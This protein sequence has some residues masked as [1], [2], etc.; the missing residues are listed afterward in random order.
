MQARP[1]A[2]S[3]L[4]AA[5]QSPTLAPVREAPRR[6]P[7]LVSGQQ[8]AQGH[9]AASSSG[10]HQRESNLAAFQ[11]A[12][13]TAELWSKHRGAL[14]QYS[15]NDQDLIRTCLSLELPSI[16]PRRTRTHPGRRSLTSPKELKE[17]MDCMDYPPTPRRSFELQLK[18]LDQR[19]KG[20]GQTTTPKDPVTSSSGGGFYRRAG[21]VKPRRPER[22]FPV[23]SAG[24]PVATRASS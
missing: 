8:S 13:S 11:E 4:L 20:G 15:M 10:S 18:P 16:K 19:S 9:Q 22:D 2:T 14:E 1:R 7:T 23:Q 3:D 24:L 5:W 21:S 12:I 17:T 6:S